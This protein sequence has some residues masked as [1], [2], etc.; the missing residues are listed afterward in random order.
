MKTRLSCIFLLL[1][2]LIGL[3]QAADSGRSAD[4]QQI[5]KIEQEWLEAIVKRD[6]AYLEKIEAPDFMVTGPSGRTLDKKADIKDTTSGATNFQSMKI[7]RLKVRLYGDTAIANGIA[8]VKATTNGKDETGT[9]AWT[10]VFV[11]MEG[12]WRAVS[13]QVTAVAEKKE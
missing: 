5:R 8:Q 2:A 3:S 6:A 1:L 13:G 12:A 7:E 11:K 9:Y 4:E 10:D